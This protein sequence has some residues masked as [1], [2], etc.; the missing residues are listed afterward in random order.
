MPEPADRRAERITLAGLVCNLLIGIG[1]LTAGILGN[2]YA[3][4]ADAAESLVDIAGSALV[5]T[6]LRYARK[7]ADHNHPYGHWRAESLA[8][9]GASLL[10]LAVGSWITW[11]A[12]DRLIHPAPTPAPWTV[13]VLIAVIAVKETLYRAM[14]VQAKRIGSDALHAEAWHHRSDAVTSVAAL[15]GVAL[16]VWGGPRFAPADPIAALLAAGIVLFNGL[17]LARLPIRDLMDTVSP[18]IAEHAEAIA[19]QD[20][21]V[22]D[23]EQAH[24]RRLG[25]RHWIDMHVE[26]NPAMT[27]ADAHRCT[28]RI[29]QAIRERIPSVADVLIHIE[30][31]AETASPDS[32][33]SRT[34]PTAF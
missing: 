34:D 3:L 26:V 2:A 6:G 23:I 20:P 29:K 30:P 11:G 14:R 10:I 8:A 31:A 1:K 13:A 32:P 19:R 17:R 18:E 7:P 33:P 16:S 9:L 15:I 21:A 27:V 24:A 28:G 25:R 5:Y 12:I 4:V 22:V